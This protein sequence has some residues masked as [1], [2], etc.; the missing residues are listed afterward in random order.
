MMKY[1]RGLNLL[2]TS[3]VVLYI[4]GVSG[5]GPDNF[6]STTTDSEYLALDSYEMSKMSEDDFKTIGEAIQRLD[7][8]EKNYIY[9]IKQTSGAQVN[10][11][12]ELFKHI[13]GGFEHT[14]TIVSR[15]KSSE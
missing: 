14:N 15:S 13:K 11:S 4:V 10:I 5:C 1:L 2:I 6:T 9:H 3:T 12:E 7:I 8:S